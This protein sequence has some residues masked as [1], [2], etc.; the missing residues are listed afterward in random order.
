M[1]THKFSATTD[2]SPEQ[3]WQL[4]ADI[5]HWGDIDQQIESIEI[6]GKPAIGTK[7]SLKPK[8]GPKLNL[9]V[10]EFTPPNLYADLCNLPLG[11]MK[12]IHSLEAIETG[13]QIQVRIEITGLLAPLWGQLVGKKHAAGLTQQTH[14][15]IE[16]TRQSLQSPTQR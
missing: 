2:L 7:F 5:V 12:T 15:L 4:L 9:K 16:K 11:C 6:Q 13:T 1:W 8:G 10:T 3:L 14:R